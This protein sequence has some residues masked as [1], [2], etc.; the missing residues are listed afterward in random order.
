MSGVWEALG[1]S[2]SL[3][4]RRL[5]R[6]LGSGPDEESLSR[7]EEALLASDMGWEFASEVVKEAELRG[8]FGEGDLLRGLKSVM[9]NRLSFLL[10][11]PPFQPPSP[12][13]PFVV[14]FTGVNGCGKTTTIAKLACRERDLGRSV[15]LAC[16]DTYRAAAGEQLEEWA[17]R[18]GVASLTQLPGSDPAA[19][20]FDAIERARSRGIDTVLIDTAGR[21]PTRSDLMAQLS[22]IHRVCGKA[23]S[24]APFET[25]LV[26]DGTVGQNAA[27]QVAAFGEALPL[28]GLVVTKLD[29]TARGGAVVVVAQRFR[30][31]I[32]FIGTG[33]RPEDL[34]EFDLSEFLD[35]L[36][37]LRAGGRGRS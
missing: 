10:E 19:V 18:T 15:L 1:R 17:R 21:L 14:V 2:R 13:S 26:L 29:G 5:S 23:L 25:L 33:E 35:A 30:I 7:A 16:A 12:E 9:M 32:R 3:L 4:S 28:S 36:L 31:P 34:A 27:A 6:L 22:K 24:G 11:P 20:A 8:A 37:G